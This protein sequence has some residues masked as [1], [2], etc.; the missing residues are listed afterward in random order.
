MRLGRIFLTILTAVGLQSAVAQPDLDTLW[1][2][3][4]SIPDE[5]P[6]QLYF[7][8]F[9]S[10]TFPDNRDS[11]KVVDTG[12]TCDGSS[13]I[14]F[15]YQFKDPRPGYAGF[16]I[17][18][19]NGFVRYNT[20]AHDSMIL[21]HKGPLPNHKVKMIWAQGGACGGP[22]N[23][24]T[25]GEFKSS[26]N[27]KRES[28]SFPPKRGTTAQYPDSAFAKDGLFELRMLIYNDTGNAPTSP[29]GCLKL[30][31][32]CFIKKTT[33]IRKAALSPEVASGPSFFAPTVCG[34]VTLAIYSL[35][36]EQLFK[37]R[38]DVSAGKRYNV[39]QFAR[40]YSNLPDAWIQCVKITGSGV[41]ITKKVVR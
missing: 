32:I 22:I 39:S 27:W 9:L 4:D 30:D 12:A 33:D 10:D 17:Y 11:F 1:L 25:F 28:F 3:R 26:T 18:W 34:Q 23:Y 16:K 7:R 36:G 37:E 31:N 38:I 6:K 21:W 41:N 40:K 24:E 8:M 19:D 2:C 15:D 20:T 35:Q 5:S 29:K 14:N 13:Y